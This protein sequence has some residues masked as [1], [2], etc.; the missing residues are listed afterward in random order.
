MTLQVLISCMHQTD[1]SIVAKSNIQ[2]DVI[3][4]NQCDKNQIEEYSFKNKIGEESR[5]KFISTT[6]RGLSRS[7]NMAIK[8]A[9][10]DICLI[11]DDDEVLDDDYATKILKAFKENS[12]DVLAFQIADI[13]KHYP[14]NKSKVGYIGALK[15][16]SVQLAFRR[17]GVIENN[18]KFDETIG[19]G[20]SKSGG[21]ENIFL[22]DCLKRSLIIFYVPI[23]IGRLLKGESQWFHGFTPECFYDHGIKTRK[24]MGRFLASVYAIH[25]VIKKYPIYHR[26][27]KLY[28]V[29]NSIY[30]GIYHQ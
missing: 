19:S 12:A 22:Y 15:L 29:I 2:S 8:N 10:A 28:T 25:F 30:K 24:L 1:H 26:D 7:R 27:I 13:G 20:V 18:I 14:A 9:T 21:E 5:V 17:R 4:V 6:E 11:C 23:K 16:A 3:V